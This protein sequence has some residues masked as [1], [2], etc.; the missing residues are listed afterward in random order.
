MQADITARKTALIEKTKKRRGKAI[1]QGGQIAA[2]NAVVCLSAMYSRAIWKKIVKTNP[3]LGVRKY[4]RPKRVRFFSANEVA[5]LLDALDELEVG[6]RV[7]AALADAIRLLML[8]GARKTEILDLKWSEVSV[9][10]RLILLPARAQRTA[11][12]VQ[13]ICRSSRLTF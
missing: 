9:E 5:S 10:R 4:T 13:S 1:V 8:T 2:A 3:C 12:C 11:S 7:R 6:N